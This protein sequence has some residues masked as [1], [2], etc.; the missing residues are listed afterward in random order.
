MKKV[1][2][3]FLYI[4]T[5][6]LMFPVTSSADTGPKPSLTIIVKGMGNEEYWMDLLVSGEPTYMWLDISDEER[7]KVSKLAEY[8]QDGLHPA[9]LKGTQTPMNGSITGEKQADGSFI[10]K[11]TYVGVP[12]VFKIAI[13]KSDGTLIIS[14]TVKRTQF[15]SIM[16]YTLGTSG[17]SEKADPYGTVREVFPKNYIWG[18]ILRMIVT[19]IIE[20][21]IALIFKFTLKKS[22]KTLLITNIVTQTAL[23]ILIIS[24]TNLSGQTSSLFIY[25]AAELFVI[26]A[27]L[28]VYCKFLVEQNLQRRILYTI[29]ANTLSLIAG[30]VL[31]SLP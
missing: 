8:N 26:A 11:F 6:L 9:L 16:E 21:G 23:N 2:M 7:K 4:I 22:W 24:A 19:L 28:G 5:C 17:I 10:H 30:F 20:I 27:E 12:S 31:F 14:D 29:S 13:L 3:V 1:G 25:F 18:F 15:Q